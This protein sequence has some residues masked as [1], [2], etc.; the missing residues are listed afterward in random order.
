MDD[1]KFVTCTTR[2]G[3]HAASNLKITGRRR[4]EKRREEQRREEKR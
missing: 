4:E 1:Y 2:F 3:A